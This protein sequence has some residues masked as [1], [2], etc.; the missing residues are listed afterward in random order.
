[1]ENY[2]RMAAVLGTDAEKMVLSYQTHTTNVRLVTEEDAGKGIVKERDYTDVDGLITNIPGITL[3]TFYADCVPLYFVDPIRKAVGLSHSGWR[4]TVHKIGKITV[5]A[6]ADQYGSRPEDIVA[7]IGPS[8]CQDCYE[9]SEDVILEFQKY[10][11]EDCQ[12]EL[13]YRKENGK[14]K[15]N[16]WRANEI[17]MEEAGILPENIHTTQWCTCC[18]PELLYS[19]R[20]SKGKRGNLAAFLG[21]KRSE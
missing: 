21:L 16:L 7:I 15:L 10:Y 1:M 18:N 14:Y 12:S 9:V 8:I 19:H 5:Q 17:V 11:R 6:M 13:Y 2:R 20:A 3:V 4:G